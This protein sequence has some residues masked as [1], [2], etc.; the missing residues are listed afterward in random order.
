MKSWSLQVN[1]WNQKRSYLNEISRNHKDKHCI[2]FLIWD[3]FHLQMW[4]LC[5][6]SLG[7]YS[8]DVFSCPILGFYIKYT[9]ALWGS[10]LN[11]NKEISLKPY[12][13]IYTHFIWILK[14]IVTCMIPVTLQTSLLSFYP[15]LLSLY[16]FHS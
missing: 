13:F 9:L 3:I 5:W 11:T 6:T 10:I 4:V 14:Q 7:N 1:E 12:I 8:K 15:F 2:L 16:C